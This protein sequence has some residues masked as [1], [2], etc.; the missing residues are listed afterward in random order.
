MD[1]CIGVASIKFRTIPISATAAGKRKKKKKGTRAR[2]NKESTTKPKQFS[3]ANGHWF[4]PLNDFRL[5]MYV[6]IWLGVGA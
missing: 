6:R 4:L 3:G 2:E 1:L 5:R